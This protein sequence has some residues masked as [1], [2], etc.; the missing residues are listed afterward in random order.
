MNEIP[1]WPNGAPEPKTWMQLEKESWTPAESAVRFRFFR[2]V[3]Q[4]TLTVFLPDP[5]IAN[6]TA[7]IVC[8]G[9]ALHVLAVDHEG[10]DVARWLNARGIAAFAQIPF[11]RDAC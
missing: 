8:P 5:E 4:P 7:V 1:F 6:R 10:Y 2:N 3:T 9:G 11:A